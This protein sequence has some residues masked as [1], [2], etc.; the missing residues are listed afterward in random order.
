M[1]ISDLSDTE[2][3][4]YAIVILVAFCIGAPTALLSLLLF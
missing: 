2:L 4:L 1:H 3:A